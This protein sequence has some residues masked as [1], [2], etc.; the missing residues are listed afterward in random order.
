MSRRDLV[1]VAVGKER[2]DA[3]ILDGNIVNVHSREIY[4]GHVAIKSGRIA[5]V[6]DVEYTVGPDTVKIDAAGRYVTPGL[7]DGHLHSYHSYLGASEFVEA[8]LSH[9]VTTTTDGFYGQGIVGGL[10][11]VRFFKETFDRLP[12]RLLFLV[13]TLSYLQNRELGLTPAEAIGID[14]MFGMLDWPGCYG[15][16][17]PPPLPIVW[18]W[19]E[20]LRLFERTLELGK[21]VSGHAIGISERELQAYIAMGGYT[22]HE[23]V[24]HHDGLLKVRSGM[25]LLMREGSGCTNVGELVRLWT[26]H[27]VDDRALAF[28]TDVASPEKLVRDGGIDQAI[29]IAISKGVPPTRAVQMGSLAVAEI[30]RADHDLGSVAPGRYADIVLVDDLPSFSISD[31]LF[32]GKHVVKDGH[33]VAVLP[34]ISYPSAFYGTVKLPD[35]VEEADLQVHSPT[36]ERE[37]QVRALSVTDGSLITKE[38]IVRLPVKDGIVSG[39][40][41]ADILPIIMIDRLG[42]GTGIGHGFVRGFGLRGGAIAS[43]V[44]A[45]C[46]NILIIGTNTADMALAANTLAS[47]GGGKVVVVD[48]EVK[49]LVELP[50]LGLLA[51]GPLGQVTQKFAQAFA[52]IRELGCDLSSPFSTMEFC[53]ACGEIGDLKIS[54]EG[55]V[56]TDPPGRVDLFVNQ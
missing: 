29:R 25:R 13:P 4:Q 32:D 33:F 39:D 21:I 7:V 2:A 45:V 43:S 22:D 31:V 27:E 46:E 38:E 3:I 42:K 19:E 23:T 12:I 35:K 20:F 36:A 5:A 24:K 11:A 34:K 37:V 15:L 48:G 28:C 14:D 41:D 6:G 50:L 16:E 30:F 47:I 44:N 56:R 1:K 10:E 40:L 51:E 52:V 9:G 18:E 53:G 49:A 26:E 8:M 54:E 17:E 55:L